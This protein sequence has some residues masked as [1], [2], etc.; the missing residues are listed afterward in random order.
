VRRLVFACK[1]RFVRDIAE[2]LALLMI[3]SLAEHSYSFLR[4]KNL[5]IVPVPLSSGRERWRGFN[6]SLEIAKQVARVLGVPIAGK[7]A[8][9]RARSA[10]PQVEV[11]HRADRFKNIRGAFFVQNTDA[12]TGKVILLID[13]VATTLAT[14]S[15]CAK[16][17]KDAGAREVW[18]I[19]AARE[20][21]KKR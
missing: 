6:Q 1:Y 3:K 21:F 12:V 2:P 8:L 4:L 11:E 9:G 7:E 17:L 15:E 19:V 20:Y 16:V 14:I 13:D 10:T 5:A 18:G